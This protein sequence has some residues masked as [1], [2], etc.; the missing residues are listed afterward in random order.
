LASASWDSS[1]SYSGRSGRRPR[2]FPQSS[3]L[4]FKEKDPFSF[5][6]RGAVPSAPC[7]LHAGLLDSFFLWSSRGTSSATTCLPLDAGWSPPFSPSERSHRFFCS[8]EE[9]FHRLNLTGVVISAAFSPSARGGFFLSS[10]GRLPHRTMK[11]LFGRLKE[12][13]AYPTTCHRHLAPTTRPSSLFPSRRAL[14]RRHRNKYKFPP[15]HQGD[16]FV[17]LRW[18]YLFSGSGL[19]PFLLEASFARFF[20]SSIL[21][22]VIFVRR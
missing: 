12:S 3:S 6:F 22:G 15:L 8:G 9:V 18:L 19:R 2:L 7:S 17:L 13:Y 1:A 16:S 10:H 20:C 4:F 14:F 21:P 11:T 5:P